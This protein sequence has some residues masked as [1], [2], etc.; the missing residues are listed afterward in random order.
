MLFKPLILIIVIHEACSHKLKLGPCVL[1]YFEPCSKNAIQFYLFSSDRPINEA[2]TVLDAAYPEFPKWANLTKDLKII[3]HGYAG[4]L[5]F[6][7][8]KTIR[9]AYLKKININVIVVDWGKMAELPCYPTAAINTKQA[10]E[11][12]AAMLMNIKG[13]HKEFNIKN[14]HGIGF[15]LG[16]HVVS[17]TSNYLKETIGL[18]LKRITGLDPALPFFATNDLNWKLDRNDADFVDVIHTNAGIY[19]KIEQCGDVDFYVNGGQN[20]PGCEQH[21]SKLI[22][23]LSIF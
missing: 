21:T 2:P 6:N 1:Q 10:G 3:V 22:F 17:F 4:N 9:N 19:G 5:D 8:T 23:L 12:T 18:K 7:A 20:Q 14:V 16:A 15:S 13:A 11:C